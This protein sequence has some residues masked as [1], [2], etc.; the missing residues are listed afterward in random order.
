[1]SKS[2]S[3]TADAAKWMTEGIKQH[4]VFQVAFGRAKESAL[5]AGFF[6]L[7]ARQCFKD[8]AWGE[9]LLGYTHK[10]PRRTVE[11]YV[12]FAEEVLKC[13]KEQNPGLVGL[14]KLSEAARQMVL[15]SPKGLVALCRELKLMRKFGEYDAVKY[16]SQKLLGDDKQQEFG[17]DYF[18]TALDMLSNENIHIKY[19]EGKDELEAVKELRAK[20]QTVINHLDQII[21]HGHVIET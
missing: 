7:A 2:L 16:R 3:Q 9:F 10:L 21:K 15:Q 13:V 19:P 18:S 14:E 11:R 8:G 20:A 4:E 1:M 5:N 12:E 6:F 17:F